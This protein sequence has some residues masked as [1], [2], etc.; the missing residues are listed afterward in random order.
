MKRISVI[1]T[2]DWAQI[3]R[4]CLELADGGFKVRALAPDHHRLHKMRTIDSEL[5]GR[6]RTAA[7][8]S[9]SRT[10]ERFLPDVVIPGVAGLIKTSLCA[11]TTGCWF[12]QQRCLR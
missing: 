4:L 1:A 5:I 9:I 10:I 6:T 2:V 12:R 7:L 3:A 8:H 11:P